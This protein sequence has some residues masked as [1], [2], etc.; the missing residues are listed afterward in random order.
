MKLNFCMI[1]KKVNI[2]L[3]DNFSFKILPVKTIWGHNNKDKSALSK[4][5]I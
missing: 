4:M 3:T 1:L 2:P 5:T